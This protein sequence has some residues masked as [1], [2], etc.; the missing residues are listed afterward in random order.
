MKKRIKYKLLNFRVEEPHLNRIDRLARKL[1]V[2]RS[3]AIRL[4]LDEAIEKYVEPGYKG[5]IAVIN[6][7]QIDLIIKSLVKRIK[8]TRP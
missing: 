5:E 4:C 3:Q 8:I 7:K 1:K 6:T 2:S